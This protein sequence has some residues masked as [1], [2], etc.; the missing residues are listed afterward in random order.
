[1]QRW[2]NDNIARH[3]V[4]GLEEAV[5]QW[6]R[7]SVYQLYGLDWPNAAWKLAHHV[8]LA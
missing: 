3:C 4:I 6:W 8:K 2:T 5:G 7:L 1:M